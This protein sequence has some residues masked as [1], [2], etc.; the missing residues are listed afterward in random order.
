[1][2]RDVEKRDTSVN[3]LQK[4]LKSPVLMAPVGV[5]KILHEEGDLASAQ[6]AGELGIP[7]VCSTVSAYSLEA[8]SEAVGENTPKW[9]QLYWSTDSDI[10]ASFLK[11]AE[12]A[13]Y[14][15]I[16]ITLDTP[17]VGW[18]ERDLNHRWLPFLEGIGIANYLTDPIFRSKLSTS[19]EEDMTEAGE[20]FREIFGNTSLSWNDIK[21]VREQTNL[22]II[23]KGILH[24]HDAELA[25]HYGA[26]GIIVSNQVCQLIQHQHLLPVP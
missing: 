9:F 13:G 25:L 14:S 8:V 5:Q 18:R 20:T 12:N 1:M 26:D 24:S 10:T 11:R 2:F 16:V 6:A 21:F 4:T 19:P 17:M 3:I 23:L 22:P 15:A 7:F